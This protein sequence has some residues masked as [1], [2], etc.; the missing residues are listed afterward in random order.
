MGFF[1]SGHGPDTEL[2]NF[3]KVVASHAL[4]QFR[5]FINLLADFY[6]SL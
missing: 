4:K 6:S 5:T 3:S 2:H 1:K